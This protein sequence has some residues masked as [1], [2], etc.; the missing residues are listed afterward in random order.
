MISKKTV[1]AIHLCTFLAQ[2]PQQRC[3]TTSTMAAALGLT[4]S[5]VEKIVKPLKEHQVVQA[6]K[7]PGGGYLIRG[8]LAGIS[9]AHIASAFLHTHEDAD[10]KTEVP[11][12]APADYELQ[13]AQIVQ[14]TL[15]EFTLA[16]FV[17]P[18]QRA[19]SAFSETTS[20]FKFKP[21]AAP[22]MPKAPNSVFQLSHGW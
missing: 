18:A 2:Q 3:T 22:F 20:R 11:H 14:D 9:L 8:D 6:I 21:M 10:D 19:A 7:G 12:S 13:L 4:V 16:S 17:N 5:Y 1:H 15:S